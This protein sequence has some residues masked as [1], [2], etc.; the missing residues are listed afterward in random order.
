VRA[1]TSLVAIVVAFTC[2]TAAAYA[3]GPDDVYNDFAADGKLSCSHSRADLR[4]VLRSGSINQY[5]DPL[6]LARLKLAVR[7]QLAGGCRRGTGS[8]QGGTAGTNAGPP[9]NGG[10]GTTS[11]AGAAGKRRTQPS[12]KRERPRESQQQTAAS[13]LASGGGNGSFVSGRALFAALLVGGLAI[14]GWLTRRALAARD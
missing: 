2:A 9:A 1:R 13:A 10:G 12:D 8:A 4:G 6:T 3:G 14:G 11:K 5:G 7:R